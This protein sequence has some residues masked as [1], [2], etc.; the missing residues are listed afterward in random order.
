MEKTNNNIDVLQKSFNRAIGGGLSGAIAMYVQVFSLMWLRTT[1]NY[2]YRYGTSTKE[3][4]QTLYKQGGIPRFYRGLT[5]ALFQGPL[6]RFGDT[7]ANVGILHFL[8]NSEKTKDLP[9]AFKTSCTSLVAGLWRIAIMPIDTS[10]T[11][12]QVEGKGG[13]TKLLTKASNHGPSVFFHGSLAAAGAT[14]VGHFPWFFT[15][16]YLDEKLPKYDSTLQNL[17]RNGAIGFAS[18]VVSDTCSN[19]VRVVKTYKQAS[20]ENISY[21]NTVKNVIK[22]DG[23][24]GLLGR[25]LKTRILANGIQGIVFSIS[26][27]FFQ[28]KF[29]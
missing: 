13:F 22:E 7:A 1:M 29:S 15:Y 18:S 14:M 10:K 3:A 6:S 11:I 28:K 23:I 20:T 25:G 19:S 17:T 12:L 21:V 5:P 2:Q 8:N 16:N 27:K 9:I 24:I 26:W 4:F